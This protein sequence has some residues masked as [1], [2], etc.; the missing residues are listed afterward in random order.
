M[1]RLDGLKVLVVE[2]EFLLSLSLQDD[3]TDA[4]CNVLTYDIR[5][6]GNS[7]AARAKTKGS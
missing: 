4:G 1:V 5:N 2:D 3:L 6:H 7:S